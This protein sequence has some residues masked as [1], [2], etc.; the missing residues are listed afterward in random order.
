VSCPQQSRL[1]TETK[2]I[3]LS[4]KQLALIRPV[5]ERRAKT[6]LAAVEAEFRTRNETELQENTKRVGVSVF[7]WEED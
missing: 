2:T 3:G 6:F 7:S 5:L 1:Y 4:A